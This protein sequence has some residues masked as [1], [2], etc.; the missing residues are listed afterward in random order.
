MLVPILVS[1]FIHYYMETR[2]KFIVPSSLQSKKFKCMASAK[3]NCY[4]FFW[5]RP[6]RPNSIVWSRLKKLGVK[7]RERYLKKISTIGIDPVLIDW[8]RFEPDCLPPVE[9]TDLHCYLVLETSYYAQKQLK[10]F[11]S[12]EA[13]NQMVSRFVCNVQGHIIGNK[14]VVLAKVRH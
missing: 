9:S 4:Y 2:S 1:C 10:D 7:V 6:C 8:K 12:L 14:F 3:K 5:S 13:Y 11:R